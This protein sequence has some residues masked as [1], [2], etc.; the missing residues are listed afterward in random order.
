MEVPH[1]FLLPGDPGA[2][3][4]GTLDKPVRHVHW[5]QDTAAPVSAQQQHH[6]H[7]GPGGQKGA[8][9]DPTRHIPI[10]IA[11]KGPIVC[12]LGTAADA[13]VPDHEYPDVLVMDGPAVQETTDHANAKFYY[14]GT[15]VYMYLAIGLLLRVAVFF[16]LTFAGSGTYAGIYASTFFL[17]VVLF[18]T[19]AFRSRP[20]GRKLL[21]FELL[22]VRTFLLV[23]V[24][25]LVLSCLT[26]VIHF[27]EGWARWVAVSLSALHTLVYIGACIALANVIQ[28][29]YII[30]INAMKL[31]RNNELRSGPLDAAAESKLKS[32]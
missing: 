6:H 1:T 18:V 2:A 8:H 27:E 3:I 10:A 15:D 29:K 32:P 13:A 23:S 21:V 25:Y 12:G 19:H 20:G 30:A 5:A 26:R 31:S 22:I 4:G 24:T 11:A 17:E 28:A 9:L 16:A 14:Y 7:V